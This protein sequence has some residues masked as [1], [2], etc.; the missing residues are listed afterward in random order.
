LSAAHSPHEFA[1]EFVDRA[2]YAEFEATC[3]RDDV[4]PSCALIA[5]AALVA[6][7]LH[8]RDDVSFYLASRSAAQR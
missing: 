5:I 8:R 6:M 7:R 4:R 2:T 1:V 3:I